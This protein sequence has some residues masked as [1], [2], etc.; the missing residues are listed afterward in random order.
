MQVVL[1]MARHVAVAGVWQAE[2][3]RGN[4]LG[5]DSTLC[6]SRLP[7]WRLRLTVAN[8]QGMARSTSWYLIHTALLHTLNR[9]RP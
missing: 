3:W 2:R 4:V 6:V 5:A 1:R 7:P 8:L 9:S